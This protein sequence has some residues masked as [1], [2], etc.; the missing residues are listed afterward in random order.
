ME[1]STE[2]PVWNPE[3]PY[4]ENVVFLRLWLKIAIIFIRSRALSGS[5]HLGLS[6]GQHALNVRHSGPVMHNGGV[7]RLLEVPSGK[8]PQI[9]RLAT[10]FCLDQFA[11]GDQCVDD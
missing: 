8:T 3:A 11:F 6:F 1:R 5:G 9:E 10:I 2:P 4:R 7:Q